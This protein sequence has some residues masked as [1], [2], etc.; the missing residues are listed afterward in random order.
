MDG[1]T[2]GRI[3]HYVITANDVET[4]RIDRDLSIKASRGNPVRAGDHVPMVMVRVF[5]NEFGEDHPGVNGQC[6][7]D[8]NDS[9][10]VT[11]A[12]YDETKEPGTWHWIEKA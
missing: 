12:K 5:P 3:A 10:W 7:L 9:L 6:L 1:L 4:I 11:S 2:E 8:G